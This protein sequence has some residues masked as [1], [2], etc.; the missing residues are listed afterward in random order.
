MS[1]GREGSI[2]NI[3][4]VPFSELAMQI[5]RQYSPKG[6]DLLHPPTFFAGTKHIYQGPFIPAI[7]FYCDKPWID[8]NSTKINLLHVNDINNQRIGEHAIKGG[9]AENVSPFEV[10]DF[11]VDR[12]GD[13]SVIDPLILVQA[14][15]L[16]VPA[17]VDEARKIGSWVADPRLRARINE[18]FAINFNNDQDPKVF[19]QRRSE[20]E[21]FVRLRK[22]PYNKTDIPQMGEYTYQGVVKEATKETYP[23]WNG[24]ETVQVPVTFRMFQP[25][26]VVWL[27][28]FMKNLGMEIPQTS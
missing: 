10:F 14:Y 18:W 12:I 11:D 8:R 28:T 24:R 25:E 5:Y 17:S 23:Y 22:A 13:N 9:I 26:D 19:S 4:T 27:E 16:Q 20:I 3:Q 2:P 1:V 15:S 7:G 21:R 6:E